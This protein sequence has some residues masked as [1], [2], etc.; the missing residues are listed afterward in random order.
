M[1]VK[2]FVLTLPNALIDRMRLFLQFGFAQLTV[3]FFLSYVGRS[4][5]RQIDSPCS[6][7]PC[8][9]KGECR[10]RTPEEG[11]GYLCLFPE[12]FSGKRC[13]ISK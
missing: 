5:S 11:H 12:G 6:P 3:P 7:S 8:F 10:A 2:S 9:N 13:E 1:R 4:F